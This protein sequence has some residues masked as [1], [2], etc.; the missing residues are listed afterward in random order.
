[1]PDRNTCYQIL[2][3]ASIKLCFQVS[4]RAAQQLIRTAGDT[5]A[6]AASNNATSAAAQ[7][8]AL[9]GRHRV[10]VLTYLK[11]GLLGSALGWSSKFFVLVRKIIAL[12]AGRIIAVLI[13]VHI[14]KDGGQDWSGDIVPYRDC[15]LYTS[16]SPRDRG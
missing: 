1:M 13:I 5:A 6:D 11:S 9:C 8:A 10:A 16:P 2:I 12:A 14:G 15:L 4:K 7:A 3:S